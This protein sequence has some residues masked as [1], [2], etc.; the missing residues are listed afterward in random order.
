MADFWI[1][2]THFSHK[3]IVRG[4]SDWGNKEKSTRPFQTIPEHDEAILDAINSVV[5]V[6]DVL[7]HLGDWSFGGVQNIVK[8]RNLIRCQNVMLIHGN[9]DY[10][11][12]KS[13]RNLFTWS[14][15]FRQINHEGQRIVMCHYAMQVWED[16][17]RGTWM[18]HGHSHNNLD[19]TNDGK[20]LDVCPE[21]H[22]YKPWSFAQLQEHMATKPVVA[23]DHHA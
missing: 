17:H 8:F 14:G 10:T 3:N 15:D 19:H 7:W 2:D 16:N 12:R 9:H 20:I 21:G 6:N 1:S 18:L 4:T 13:Y 23:K 22:D 5:G 11:L